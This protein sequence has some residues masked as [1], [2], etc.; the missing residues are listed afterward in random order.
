MKKESKQKE[1]KLN[2]EY[3]VLRCPVELDVRLSEKSVGY[4]SAGRRFY[5]KIGRKKAKSKKL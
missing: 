3:S 2:T 1:Y 4:K 5:F